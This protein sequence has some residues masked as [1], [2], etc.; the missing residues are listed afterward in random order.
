[1]QSRAAVVAG[2]SRCR[3]CATLPAAG[4]GIAKSF[5]VTIRFSNWG[6]IA[7]TNGPSARPAAAGAATTGAAASSPTLLIAT[8]K[9]LWF[10]AS[11]AARNAW[12]LE[13]PHFLG[14]IV[15]HTKFDPRDGNTLLVAAR[16]GHLG[17]TVLRSIDG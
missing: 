10:L 11:D 14:H 12:R 3:R 13:G 16:T 9:G 8:R 5:A 4:D 15:H 7:M 17:H 1:E 6:E 2:E